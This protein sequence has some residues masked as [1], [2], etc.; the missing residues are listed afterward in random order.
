[1]LYLSL[2]S[3]KRFKNGAI[4]FP[5]NEYTSSINQFILAH[6]LISEGKF[7][8]SLT[9]CVS[10][11]GARLGISSLLEAAHL[12]W[13]L[14]PTFPCY[15]ALGFKEENQMYKQR[16]TSDLQEVWAHQA[17]AIPLKPAGSFWSRCTWYQ[18]LFLDSALVECERQENGR[19][20]FAGVTPHAPNPLQSQSSPLQGHPSQ[21]NTHSLSVVQGAVETNLKGRKIMGCS[22]E[23]IT[24][25]EGDGYHSESRRRLCSG[26]APC[27]VSALA[28]AISAIALV[29]V[30]W[31]LYS[32]VQFLITIPI[33]QLVYSSESVGKIRAQG[34]K[35]CCQAS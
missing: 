28:P 9:A 33:K 19:G 12:G 5:G 3:L 16:T 29:S 21:P 30:P 27:P 34:I 23:Q 13:F 17:L 32:F 7:L 22:E 4:G 2:V 11:F 18:G 24:A 6:P 26:V 35:S 15:S 14:P 10:K 31:I 25:W 20:C 8:T 1:M